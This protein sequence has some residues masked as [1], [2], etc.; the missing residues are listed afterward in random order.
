M[1]ED[2]PC[3]KEEMGL[4]PKKKKRLRKKKEGKIF[5][6]SSQLIKFGEL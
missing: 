1:R 4:S 3:P 5:R 2:R 6:S